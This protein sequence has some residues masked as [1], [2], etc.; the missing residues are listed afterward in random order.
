M[1]SRSLLPVLTGQASAHRECVRSGLDDWRMVWDGRHKLV[2]SEGSG[3]DGAPEV[4]LFD[5]VEDPSETRDVAAERPAEVARLAP[6]LTPAA[7]G[8]AMGAER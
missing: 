3:T 2:R 8:A 1:D 6:L 7:G 4:A 5:L